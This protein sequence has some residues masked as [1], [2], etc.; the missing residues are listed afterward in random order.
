MFMADALWVVALA[1]SM[2]QERKMNRMGDKFYKFWFW[3]FVIA[4]FILGF[5]LDPMGR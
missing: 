2:S 1:H 3:V 4:A 5:I